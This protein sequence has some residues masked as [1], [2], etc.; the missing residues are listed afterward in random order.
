[1]VAEFFSGSDC[2]IVAS[3]LLVTRSRYFACAGI[4]FGGASWLQLLCYHITRLVDPSLRW[5]LSVSFWVRPRRRGISAAGS[6]DLV[7]WGR[8]PGVVACKS[9]DRLLLQR[10]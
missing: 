8:G 7:P 2:K 5:F 6:S 3:P 9:C 10:V 1:M 4:W